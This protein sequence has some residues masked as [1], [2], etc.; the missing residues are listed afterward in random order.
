[1]KQA[2][3]SRPLLAIAAAGLLLC[4]T[5]VDVTACPNCRDTLP[6]GQ[7]VEGQPPEAKVAQGFAWSIYLM[8]AVPF[9]LAAT[10]G[11]AA[12]VLIRKAS[13]QPAPPSA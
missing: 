3:P 9:T 13:Q 1:M 7:Q 5:A 2:T 4:I 10:L 12:F 8:L 11:G 6:N